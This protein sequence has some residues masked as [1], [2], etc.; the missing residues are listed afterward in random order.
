MTGGV[1]PPSHPLHTPVPERTHP[2]APPRPRRAYPGRVKSADTEFSGG[3]LDGRVLPVLLGMMH[4]VPKVYRVPV[5]AHGDTP[6]TVLVYR[7]AKEYGPKGRYRWR[8]EY[9]ADA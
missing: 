3:P 9:D 6:A 1:P 7:R 4:S 5:P 8:Y 2:P